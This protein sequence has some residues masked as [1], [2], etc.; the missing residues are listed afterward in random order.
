M[1][2][3]VVVTGVGLVCPLGDTPAELRAARLLGQAALKDLTRF[4]TGDL[5]R[6][7]VGELRF[8]ASFRVDGKLTGTVES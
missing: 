2:R 6:H 4:E 8:D 3:Q 1:Q 5:P 7:A